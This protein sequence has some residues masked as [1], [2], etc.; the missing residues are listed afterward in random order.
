MSGRFCTSVGVTT[1]PISDL[2]VS[3]SGASEVTST[4][5]VTAPALSLTFRVCFVPTNTWISLINTLL[6]PRASTVTSYL[7]GGN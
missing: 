6:K 1:P 3:I 7:P 5:S 4:V 2:V